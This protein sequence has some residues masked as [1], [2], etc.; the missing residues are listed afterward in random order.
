[1]IGATTINEYRKHI[2]KDAALE[3]RFQ[4]VMVNEPNKE[5]AIAILRGIKDAYQTH[6]WVKI[7]DEAVVAAVDLSIKYIPDRRLPDKAI[8]L[9]DE[10]SASVKMGITSMPEDL[11][12]LE[13]KLTQL[14]IEKQAL[15]IENNK[16][17]NQRLESLEK[18]LAETKESYNSAKANREE[19]RKLLV[20]LKEHKEE[21]KKLEHEAQIAE[22]QTDYNKVAEIKYS[23]IPAKQKELKQIEKKIENSKAEWN[24][25]LK[26][27]V[28]TEDIAVIIAKR[29]GIPVS[30]LVESEME[31]LAHLEDHL[32]KEVIWQEVAITAVA[33][34]IRRARAWLKDTN[35]PIGSFI[36]LGPTGVGKTE[37]TKSLA[38]F[39]FN[40]PKAMVRLD[41]SEYMEKHSV[42]KLIG[43]PPGYIGHDEWWQLTEAIRRKPYSVILFDEIEKAHPDVSNTLLQLLDDGRLTDSKGRTVDFKHS[44]II[45]TSN[46]GSQIIMDKLGQTDD[47]K[48]E[49]SLEKDMMPL[50]QQQ[51]RPEF[52][53]RVDDIIIFN[54][55]SQKML[56]QIV[57]I[58]IEEIKNMLKRD[59]DITLDISA[60]AFDL[61]ANKWRD[62]QF[63]ARPLKRAIQKHLIDELALQIIEW[64]IQNG[65]TIKVQ[66]DK[67]KIIFT[68]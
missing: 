42:A 30:K 39:M 28:E 31:K 12:K 20:E 19:D 55:I 8:D 29:T 7:A 36:F 1:M 65:D 67:G 56:Y 14:E 22:K 15:S 40:D 57:G 18:E 9:L 2:E 52:L 32:S 61:I 13:K 11:A 27:I 6:H 23:Q 59:K 10:A 51:F 64:K 37:L 21:L 17:N 60:K 47:K 58:Q 43:S 50:L 66:E 62:P 63:G 44:I 53:N 49:L 34:A 33:N 41:M 5:D 54:P 48:K 68:K 3:R 46:I 35:K 26:D 25:I 16:K 24:I 38:K 45:M 4:P